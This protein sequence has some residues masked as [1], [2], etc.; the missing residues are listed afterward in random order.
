MCR[1]LAVWRESHHRPISFW[2][3]SRSCIQAYTVATMAVADREVLRDV[4]PEP[5]YLGFNINVAG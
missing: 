4:V 2:C 1:T 3:P 5:V